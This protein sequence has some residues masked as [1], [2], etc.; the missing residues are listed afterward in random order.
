M[1]P[2]CW[3]MVIFAVRIFWAG[4]GYRRSFSGH[5]LLA[6]FCK[7]GTQ[8]PQCGTRMLPRLCFLRGPQEGVYEAL[9]ESWQGP[10]ASP[11][12]RT[13]SSGSPDHPPQPPDL[14]QR[15]CSWLKTWPSDGGEGVQGFDL[16]GAFPGLVK[17]LEE[18]PNWSLFG[19]PESSL[20]GQGLVVISPT[21]PTG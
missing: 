20:I 7:V 3:E 6:H 17:G 12:E 19:R 2:G 9:D 15:P 14:Q 16:A 13:G 10:P 5:G 21:Q 1:C 18:T 8:G 4:G 11:G